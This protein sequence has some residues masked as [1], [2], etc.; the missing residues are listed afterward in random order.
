MQHNEGIQYNSM[1]SLYLKCP[2][3]CSREFKTVMC[4]LRNAQELENFSI[5]VEHPSSEIGLFCEEQCTFS[6]K[7]KQLK[8]IN[9]GGNQVELRF[10]ECVLGNA[11]L[12]ENIRIHSSFGID[13]N[14]IIE[15]FNQMK[16]LYI[17]KKLLS[18]PRA[19]TRARVE[20]K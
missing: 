14:E 9:V 18:F 13:H 10:I 8:M 17:C 1:R 4:I 5:F 7:L 11:S 20:V 16:Q 19:S 12:L 15:G 2:L 6:T 3:D